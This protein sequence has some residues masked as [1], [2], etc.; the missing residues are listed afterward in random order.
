MYI[1]MYTFVHRC[2]YLHIRRVFLHT[3]KA[4]NKHHER[5][6][7]QYICTKTHIYAYT[8]IEYLQIGHVFCASTVL[9]KHHERNV[10]QYI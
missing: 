9:N 6:G 4:L 7:I 8:Y 5:N 3:T 2:I 1:Y 10:N